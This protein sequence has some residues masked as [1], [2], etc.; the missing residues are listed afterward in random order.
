MALPVG[1][2]GSLEDGGPIHCALA[3]PSRFARDQRFFVFEAVAAG[4]EVLIAAQPEIHPG[5]LTP[6]TVIDRADEAAEVKHLEGA[7]AELQ[8]AGAAEVEMLQED[9][10]AAVMPQGGEAVAAA[11]RRAAVAVEV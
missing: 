11:M 6:A 2:A 9:E 4:P 1:P 10:E 7:A 8:L 3:I 5:A